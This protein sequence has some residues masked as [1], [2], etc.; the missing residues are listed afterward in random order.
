M[1]WIKKYILKY[2][3][4][5]FPNESKYGV[6]RIGRRLR[7]PRLVTDFGLYLNKESNQINFLAPSSTY[8]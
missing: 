2:S 1:R 7:L 8:C 6:S 5:I 3:K 4:K